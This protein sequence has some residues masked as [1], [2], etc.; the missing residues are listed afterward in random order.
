MTLDESIRV[1]FDITEFQCDP[2]VVTK[3]LDIQPSS[4]WREGD[5]IGPV[6][7]RRSSNGWR[8]AS[9]TDDQLS[10]GAHVDDVL[11]RLPSDLEKM[12][13]VATHWRTRLSVVVEM[14]QRTPGFFIEAPWI[15]KLASLGAELDVDLYLLGDGE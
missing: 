13:T 11:G 5:A 6:G 2:D 14:Q 8:L 1:F 9:Q 10:V 15:S 4:T 12:H 7:P 3:I